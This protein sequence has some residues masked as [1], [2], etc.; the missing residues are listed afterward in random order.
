MFL[1]AVICRSNSVYCVYRRQAYP[2][3]LYNPW[4]KLWPAGWKLPCCDKS[5]SSQIHAW[6]PCQSWSCSAA[7]WS[8]GLHPWRTKRQVLMQTRTDTEQTTVVSGIT[9]A[10]HGTCRGFM[11]KGWTKLRKI[12]CLTTLCYTTVDRFYIYKCTSCM[13]LTLVSG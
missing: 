8:W 7:C 6:R 13:L 12:A 1:R 5:E 3:K 2:L 4:W 11:S 10:V 9:G